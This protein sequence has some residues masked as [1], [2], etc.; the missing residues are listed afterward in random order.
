MVLFSGQLL[1]LLVWLLLAACVTPELEDR[2]LGRQGLKR[3]E[4]L[5]QGFLRAEESYAA[6]RD[7]ALAADR[8]F[9]PWLAKSMV[10][11]AVRD[12]DRLIAERQIPEQW[13]RS[14]AAMDSRLFVRA[15]RELVVLGQDGLNAIR[16][17]LLRARRAQ[18]R[19]IG[20]LLLLGYPKEQL[21]SIVEQELEEGTRASRRSMLRLLADLPDVQ[22][23]LRLLRDAARSSDWQIRGEALRPLAMV[24]RKTGEGDGAAF[25]WSAYRGDRDD[26]VRR[27]ALLAIGSLGD[28]AQARPLIDALETLMRGDR[29]AEAEAAA[30]GLRSLTGKDFKTSVRRWRQWLGSAK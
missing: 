24:W 17:Y 7:R 20:G 29:H 3:L 9:G 18:L 8:R 13:I 22:Q 5:E 25:L 27:Q 14:S 6:E 12:Y 23:S 21:F 11:H 15:R 10:N 26:F 1:P 30:E 4:R 19:S 16:S 28:L 2:S